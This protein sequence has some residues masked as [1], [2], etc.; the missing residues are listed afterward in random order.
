MF[1]EEKKQGEVKEL[2][3]ASQLLLAAAN[4][5]E[6]KQLHQGDFVSPDFQ[7]FC[8]MGAIRFAQHGDPRRP[9]YGIGNIAR[10][11][12]RARLGED[13]G[14]AQWNDEPGRTKEE[15]VAMLRAVAFSS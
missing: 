5:L 14:P 3:A 4:F 13:D 10:D 6:R 8:L 15:V 9:S 12:L 11:R 2:D 7:R 1:V